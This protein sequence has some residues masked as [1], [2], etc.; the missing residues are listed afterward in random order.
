[1]K[2]NSAQSASGRGSFLGDVRFSL[3]AKTVY[4]ATRVALPPLVL[5]H[6]P[7]ADYGVWSVAFIVVSYLGLTAT[8]FA[9]VY[10]RRGA[11]AHLDGD[12]ATLS[13]LLSTGVACLGM[14]S[15]L[16]LA[17][18]WAGLPKL[19]VALGVDPELRATAGKLVFGACAVFLADISLGAYAYLLHGIGRI[20]D[21][22]GIWVIAFLGE[23]VIAMAL[24]VHGFGIVSLLLAFALRYVFSIGATAWVAH[25][26]LPGLRLDPRLFDRAQLR[27]F[28]G[29]GLV[30][31]VS[32]LCANALHS[33]ERVLAA[34]LLGAPAAALFD[35]GNKLPST[36]TSIPSAVS[37][38]TMP[39]AARSASDAEVAALYRRATR[40]TALLTALPMPF[41][42]LFAL[43]LCQFWLGRHP[44]VGSVAAIMSALAISCHFH[45][46]TGPGSAIYRGRGN[47]GNEFV[48]H[49][50][51]TICLAAAIAVLAVSGMLA[52]LPL[53][54]AVGTAGCL[55]ALAYLA[56]N[57][58][59]LTGSATGLAGG[60][61]WP[62][63]AGYPAALLVH[64][65]ASALG[66]WP[67]DP[68]QGRGQLFLP[69]L[70][71][72]TSY[73][74]GAGATIYA[75]V[76][77]PAERTA[78]LRAIGRRRPAAAGA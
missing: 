16:I 52:L 10:V 14:V 59:G 70:I 77:E 35:L 57:H 12:I 25:R 7:L 46:L 1:M 30:V 64:A 75:F 26:A 31:Q 48:Y 20:R 39:A 17:A 45:I 34:V 72:G 8:G 38:V 23:V 50:L 71:A 58:R 42:C 22:Q 51:R 49:G 61:L 62:A 65:A 19:L 28:F 6:V 73:A 9:S 4:L 5:A 13:R 53:A 69:L 29:F 66:L 36:A 15:L 24:L 27:E 37:S 2:E 78:L 11:I 32:A 74:A 55:A 3:I 67:A 44:E 54:V 41:L 43:P 56:W 33:A 21:E 63:C 18:L 47:A 68:Q 40:L 76:L 60:L